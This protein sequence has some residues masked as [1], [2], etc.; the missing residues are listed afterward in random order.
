MSK[1]FLKAA[2][3]AIFRG[4]KKPNIT[5]ITNIFKFARKNSKIFAAWYNKNDPPDHPEKL[6]KKRLIFFD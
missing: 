4:V 5:N 3:R 1:T 6:T 2:C